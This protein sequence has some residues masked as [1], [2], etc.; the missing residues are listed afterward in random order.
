MSTIAFTVMGDPRPAGSKKGFF[1]GGH[2]RIVDDNPAPLKAWRQAVTT[3]AYEARLAAECDTFHGPCQVDIA[4]TLPRPSGARKADVWKAT[5]P[6]ID[7]LLRS[8]LD[9]LTDAAIFTDDAL[10]CRL[11][12]S[13]KM[14]ARNSNETPGAY[15]TVAELAP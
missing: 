14:V 8:T 13:K 7:K 9:G 4:F 12:A 6:D 1:M 5:K 11:S 15:I 2:V 3:A 10:V